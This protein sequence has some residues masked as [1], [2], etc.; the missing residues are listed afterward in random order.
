M[1][2]TKT[3]T[4]NELRLLEIELTEKVEKTVAAK[5]LKKV[6]KELSDRKSNAWKPAVLAIVRSTDRIEG[7]FDKQ[8]GSPINWIHYTRD[9]VAKKVDVVTFQIIA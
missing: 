9:Q 1:K 7:R 3:M 8:F 4:P 6:K 5:Q 2:D